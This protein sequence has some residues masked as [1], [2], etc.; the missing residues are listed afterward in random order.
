MLLN[1]FT[2]RATAFN[3]PKEPE[4]LSVCGEK[5]TN[6]LVLKYAH[7]NSEICFDYSAFSGTKRAIT[8]SL[9]KI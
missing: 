2:A 7:E 6:L 8:S 1:H 5:G 3:T 4:I 9:K